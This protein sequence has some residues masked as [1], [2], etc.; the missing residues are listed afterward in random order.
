MHT[1][2]L[3]ATLSSVPRP[4]AAEARLWKRL[5]RR[6]PVWWREVGT[7]IW[8]FDFYCPY[9]RLAVEVDGGY[10]RQYRDRDDHR[11]RD[12]ADPLGNGAYIPAPARRRTQ[13]IRRSLFRLTK[14][15][16]F[17]RITGRGSRSRPRAGSTGWVAHTSAT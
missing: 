13:E 8:T 6:E 7:D 10:H 14:L 4:T 2:W 12:N 9:A 11:D 15:V 5:R 1:S 3:A 17:D 16:L